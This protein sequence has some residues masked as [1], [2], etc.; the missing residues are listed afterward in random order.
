M[1]ENDTVYLLLRDCVV[2]LGTSNVLL[3]KIC[4]VCEPEFILVLSFSLIEK[5]PQIHFQDQVTVKVDSVLDM[6]SD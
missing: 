5:I 4:T 2:M 1:T 6:L 3:E